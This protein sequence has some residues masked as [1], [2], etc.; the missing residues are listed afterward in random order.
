MIRNF[1][2]CFLFVIMGIIH[3]ITKTPENFQNFA[4]TFILS[5]VMATMLI[6]FVEDLR[7]N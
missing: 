1:I 2:T 6:D 7:K 5:F 4:L 3:M